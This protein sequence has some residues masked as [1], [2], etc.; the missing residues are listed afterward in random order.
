MNKSTAILFAAA[1]LTTG[2]LSS[3]LTPAPLLPA[4]EAA[5]A[6]HSFIEEVEA[7]YKALE[8]KYRGL[9]D[10]DYK[11]AHEAYDAFYDSIH[12]DQHRLNRAGEDDLAY[13]TGLLEDDLKGLKER[14]SGSSARDALS[15]YQRQSNPNSSSGALW[16]YAAAL[17]ENYSS[18]THWEFATAI[19]ENYSSSLMWNYHKE[20]NENYSGSLMWEYSS[21][22]NPNYSGSTMWELHNESNANYSGS[23]MNQYKLGNLS[24]QQAEARMNELLVQGEKDLEAIRGAALAGLSRTQQETVQKLTAL[25]DSTV[26]RI[27]KQ[28]AQSLEEIMAVRKRHFG[29]EI[30]VKPLAFGFGIQVVIDGEPQT[31]EQPPVNKDGSILV[32]MRAIFERLGA[33]LTWNA[34]ERSVTAVKKETTVYLKLDSTEPTVNGTVKPL[35]VPAQL[36][37]SNTMV[38]VRFISEALGAEVSWDGAAQTVYIQTK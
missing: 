10:A 11:Q 8:S 19:N 5:A 4:A 28:R 33:V 13:L 38:P 26:S 17:N 24:R 31:Y 9:Y 34:Q 30:A 16:E 14:Y 29:G 6:D 36:V 2:S 18:S 20:I 12:N 23:V 27:L 25:R 1:I 35:E 3:P 21:E 15:E 32:P 7:R 22:T 37:N